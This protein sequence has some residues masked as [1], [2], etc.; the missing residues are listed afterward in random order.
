MS[1]NTTKNT[2][3]RGREYLLWDGDCGFCRRSAEII[4]RLDER[5]NFMVAPY[6]SFSQSELRKVGLSYRRCARELQIVTTSGKT[7]GGAFAVNYFLWRQPRLKFLVILG[8]LFP[9][10]LLVEVVLYQIVAGNRLLFSKILF[11]NH[12]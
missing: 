7:F 3:E 8:F 12:K 10:L 4:E 6:Q 11:P 2:I 5:G 9:L 1:E